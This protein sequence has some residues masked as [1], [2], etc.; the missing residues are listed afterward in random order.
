MMFTSGLTILFCI[1]VSSDLEPATILECRTALAQCEETIKTMSTYMPDSRHYV[2]FFK[3]ICIH[4]FPKLE[5]KEPHVPNEHSLGSSSTHLAHL[6]QFQ[7]QGNGDAHLLESSISGPTYNADVDCPGNGRVPL[8]TDQ[9]YSHGISPPLFNQ[10]GIND[11]LDEGVNISAGPLDWSFL[12]E[13][14]VWNIGLG[15]YVYGN[16]SE[17][18]GLFETNELGQNSI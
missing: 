4:V 15:N 7:P 9:W 10:E 1:S 6:D 11:V 16:L 12:G 13:D 5:A 14:A 3:A 17:L 2:K 8:E 18:T